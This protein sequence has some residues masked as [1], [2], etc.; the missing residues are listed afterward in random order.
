MLG[1]SPENV[2][3][4]GHAGTTAAIP[5]NGVRALA[6]R[7]TGRFGVIELL[8]NLGIP[9][10]TLAVDARPQIGESFSVTRLFKPTV[11]PPRMMATARAKI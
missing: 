1:P 6:A 10:A 2:A 11:Q 7:Q 4:L 3:L 5:C 8:L 9:F